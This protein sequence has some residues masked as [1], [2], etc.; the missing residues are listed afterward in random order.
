[1]YEITLSPT[2]TVLPDDECWQAVQNRDRAYDGRFVTAVH[3][4]GIYCRPS[5]PA[6]TPHR[7][8]ITFCHTPEEAEAAGFRPCKRCSPNTQAYD[9]DVTER[10][11]RFIDSHLDE[12]LTL[13]ELGAVGALSPQHLQR[14]FKRTLG[15]SPREYIEARRME[16]LKSRLKA[17][18]KVTDALYEAGFSSSSRLYERA[19]DQFGMTP[20]AYRRGGEGLEITYA[21]VQSSLGYVLVAFTERGICAVSLGDSPQQLTDTLRADFPAATITADSA[22]RSAQVALLL[23]HLEGQQPHIELPLDIRGTAFQRRVW[24]ALQQI[25]SGET[26]SYSQIAASLG[27]PK[28]TRA[29]ARACASNHIAVI[30][31]CHRVIRNDGAMGGY[32]WGL[33]RKQALLRRERENARQ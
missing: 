11:C 16:H 6:R 24:Q 4:T 30:I 33:S 1:M 8:N 29:V 27:E 23:Q 17:G 12:R 15:I 28:A 32:R 18:E 22:A 3:T 25:P 21:V 31:P 19:A 2:T 26:R 20:A 10:I 9:A 14:V 7:R 13:D 5:C